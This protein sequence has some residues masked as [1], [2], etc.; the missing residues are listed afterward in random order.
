MAR[1]TIAL[2]M[3]LALGFLVAPLA[4][5]AQPQGKIPQIGYLTD[6]ASPLEV[7]AFQRALR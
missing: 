5:A 2:L 7:A 3:T 6:S 1:R 4:A